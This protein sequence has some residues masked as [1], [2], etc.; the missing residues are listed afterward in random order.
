MK[1]WIN[2]GLRIQTKPSFFYQRPTNFSSCPFY[3][4]WILFLKLEVYC[5]FCCLL[6]VLT[7]C[8]I[9]EGDWGDLCFLRGPKDKKRFEFQN[10]SLVFLD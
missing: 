5:N 6:P 1:N 10:L 7:N 3:T 9:W 8:Q 2:K 4:S